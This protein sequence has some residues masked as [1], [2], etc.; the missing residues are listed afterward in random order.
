[1]TRLLG[2][3]LPMSSVI[4]AL[5]LVCINPTQLRLPL[6]LYFREETHCG[7]MVNPALGIQTLFLVH[8]VVVR[9]SATA[10]TIFL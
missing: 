6:M 5:F 2:V 7:S 10:R 1:M 4:F 3:Q 8:M 9:Y